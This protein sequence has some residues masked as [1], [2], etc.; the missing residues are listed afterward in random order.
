[1]PFIEQVFPISG[2][3]PITINI[4]QPKTLFTSASGI[5]QSFTSF[6]PLGRRNYVVTRETLSNS[7]WQ[8]A[9]NFLL[10]CKGNG[11]LYADFQDYQVVDEILGF[12]DGIQDTFEIWKTY[13]AGFTSDRRRLYKIKNNGTAKVYLDDIE[14]SSGFAINYIL[15]TVVFDDAGAINGKTVKFSGEFYVP[16]AVANSVFSTELAAVGPTFSNIKDIQLIEIVEYQYTQ[17]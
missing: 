13:S 16:V 11:F 6:P 2:T 14:Q 8:E 12:G 15:G 1:M 7:E 3:P 10:L 9:I 17:C 4:E 5:I